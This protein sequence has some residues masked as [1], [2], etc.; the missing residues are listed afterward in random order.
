MIALQ[1]HGKRWALVQSEIPNRTTSQ[2]RTHAQKFFIKLAYILPEGMDPI[3]FMR[4]KTASFFLDLPNRPPT[5]AAKRQQSSE[6]SVDPI[7]KKAHSKYLFPP[8][9]LLI[10]S[11]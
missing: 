3:T 7:P 6:D 8:L 4:T 10:F 5:G 1:K 11:F 2:I 9:T